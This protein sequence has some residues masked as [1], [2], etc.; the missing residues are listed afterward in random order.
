MAQ[1]I[2]LR[3]ALGLVLTIPAMT[4]ARSG[5]L[6]VSANDGNAPMVNGSYKVDDAPA[7][8]TLA[9]ID[10]AAEGALRDTG[11]RIKLPAR[12][13]PRRGALSRGPVARQRRECRAQAA[14]V[15]PAYHCGG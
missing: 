11:E 8:D 10:A 3:L 5:S 7:A 6:I 2:G 4:A 12:R 13:H 9:V 1:L 15:I 14:S